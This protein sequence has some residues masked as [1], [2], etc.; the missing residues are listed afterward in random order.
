MLNIV[1]ELGHVFDPGAGVPTIFIN[2]RDT[3]LRSNRIDFMWQSNK[4][5]TGPET[6]GDFFVAWVYGVWG[7]NGNTVWEGYENL[8]SAKDW[9]TTNMS[10]WVRH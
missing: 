7:S 9:M 8:G 6:F 1:H 4:A 5:K 2:N 3:I 10:E